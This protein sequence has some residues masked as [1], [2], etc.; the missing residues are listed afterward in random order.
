MVTTLSIVERLTGPVWRGS[1]SATFDRVCRDELPDACTLVC[2]RRHTPWWFA[3]VRG[4]RPSWTCIHEPVPGIAE[5]GC[6]VRVIELARSIA[7]AGRPAVWFCLEGRHR[8]GLLAAAALV[9]E[10]HDLPGAVREFWRFAD[11]RDDRSQ[12]ALRRLIATLGR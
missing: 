8:S 3:E 1:E 7:V 10:N 2:L 4:S 6:V 11:R 9:V 12:T 5:S